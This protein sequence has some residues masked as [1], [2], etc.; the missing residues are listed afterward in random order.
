MP[1]FITRVELHDATYQDYVKLHGYMAQ[2]GFT[3]TIRSDDGGLYQLP[4][5]EYH[6]VVNC[7]AAQARDKASAA[8]QKTLKKFAVIASEYTAAAWVGLAKAQVRAA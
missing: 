6:L 2:E 5:A 4:P 8:A 3:N 7:T 1:T